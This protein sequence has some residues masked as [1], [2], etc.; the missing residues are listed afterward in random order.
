M[1][2]LMLYSYVLLRF[3]PDA[4]TGERLNVGLVFY[5]SKEHLLIARMRPS[6]TRITQAFPGVSGPGLKRVLGWVQASIN[7][8]AVSFQ[9]RSKPLFEIEPQSAADFAKIHLPDDDSSL[10]W[11][12]EICGFTD[13]PAVEFERL[14]ARLVTN[15]DRPIER[16]RRSDADI[17]LQYLRHFERAGLA[18]HLQEHVV[19][20]DIEP[21]RFEHAL[22]NG[23]WHCLEPMSF[24]LMRPE[25][26]K[27]KAREKFAAMSFL[28]RQ[29]QD[30]KVYFLLGEPESDEGKRAAETAVK[31][32]L[33]S[34][35]QSEIVHESAGQSFVDRMVSL[36]H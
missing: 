34:P 12:E 1:S 8:Y 32:L 25:S 17:W 10:Q 23:R 35:I 29:D 36:V 19:S 33:R 13:N 9:K 30:L 20:G 27:S 14:F 26:I 5:C 18:P 7:R 31:I 16:A 22:K 28:D 11:S 2:N 4:M 15:Y 21:Y 24:D 3:M 6:I